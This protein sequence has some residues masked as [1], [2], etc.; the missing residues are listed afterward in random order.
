MNMLNVFAGEA[1]LEL[2]R[3]IAHYLDVEL[4]A[5]EKQKFADGE[6]W[7]KY[8]QNIRGTDVFLIQSLYPPA[9]HILELLF[10]IDAAKRASARRITAVIPYFGYARQ[11]RK[12]RPRVAISA[13]VIADLLTTVGSDRVL[14]MDLHVDQI[15]GFFSIPVD[16]LYASYVFVDYY[17][18][19]NLPN[20]AISA[21]DIGAVKLAAAYAKRLE[22]E[23]VVVDKR[24]PRPNETYVQTIIGEVQSRNVLLV[25]D[26]IDTGGSLT[27]AATA[28]KERGAVDI[29]ACCSHP[30]LSLDAVDKVNKSCLTELAVTDTIPLKN[31]HASSKIKVI[32]CSTMVGEAIKRTHLEQSISSLFV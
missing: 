9:E 18:K 23:L 4:G 19:K 10:M 22:A 25:D 2:G 14:T 6:I 12:D 26:L 29:Y 15:Q 28:L 13:R 32:S 21:P 30:L 1:S 5:L 8:N 17:R 24:R 7:I 16:H 31:P 20:L 3:K 11:D 27:N